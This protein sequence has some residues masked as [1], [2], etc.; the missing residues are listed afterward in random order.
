[1]VIAKK[2]YSK[3]YRGIIDFVNE[4]PIKLYSLPLHLLLTYIFNKDI[5]L[6]LVKKLKRIGVF[7]NYGSCRRITF[8]SW[9][10]R[11]A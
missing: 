9:W 10:S 7:Y 2:R 11:Q 6:T 5:L 8:K 1:M 4:S 3:T